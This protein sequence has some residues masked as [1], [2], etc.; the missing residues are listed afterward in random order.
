MYTGTGG[1]SLFYY[2][3][4][5]FCATMGKFDRFA[6]LSENRENDLEVSINMN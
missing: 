1:N 3:L 6:D 4:M 2:R 5:T